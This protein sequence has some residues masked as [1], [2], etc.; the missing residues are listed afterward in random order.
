MRVDFVIWG[1]HLS[2]ENDVPFSVTF[3][4]RARGM[5]AIR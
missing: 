1:S 4:F 3:A 2:S 5:W